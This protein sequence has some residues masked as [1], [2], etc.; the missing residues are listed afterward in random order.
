MWKCE[1]YLADPGDIS[2]ISLGRQ[3]IYDLSL[4]PGRSLVQRPVDVHHSAYSAARAAPSGIATTVETRDHVCSGAS[5]TSR[6]PS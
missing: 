4:C 5:P 2:L 1:S 6:I 3:W